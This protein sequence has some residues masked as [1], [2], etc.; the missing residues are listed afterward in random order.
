[1]YVQ[2]VSG[3]LDW[4][5]LDV[6]F[7]K[8]DV[9]GVQRE[10]KLNVYLLELFAFDSWDGCPKSRH[11]LSS[12]VPGNVIDLVAIALLVIKVG[13]MKAVGPICVQFQESRGNDVIVQVDSLA[14]DVAFPLQYQ[15]RFVGD[16]EVVLD[17]LAI[18]DI[19]AIGEQGE[20]A[21]H[22]GDGQS[23]AGLPCNG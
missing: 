14:A 22:G 3:Y 10:R 19:A 13:E 5:T 1:M 11:A 7:F 18:E 21:R 15:A 16:D 8:T 6:F 4:E 23:Q 9:I 2:P 12:V 20:P 17:E